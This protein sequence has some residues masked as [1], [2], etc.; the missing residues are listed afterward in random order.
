M[1]AVVYRLW[2]GYRSTGDL[3]GRVAVARPD[4]EII[5]FGP[6]NGWGRENKSSGTISFRETEKQTNKFPLKWLIDNQLLFSQELMIC[7]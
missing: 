1:F 3:C 7:Q 4:R 2:T 6:C 5:C